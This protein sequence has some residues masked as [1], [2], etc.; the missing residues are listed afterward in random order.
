MFDGREAGPDHDFVPMMKLAELSRLVEV[1]SPGFDNPGPAVN[2]WRIGM[3]MRCIIAGEMD[4]ARMDSP[5][6]YVPVSSEGTSWTIVSQANLPPERHPRLDNDLRTLIVQCCSLNMLERPSLENVYERTRFL[7]DNR[8]AEYFKGTPSEKYETT[9][10]CKDLMARLL[11]EAE[12][13]RVIGQSMFDPP[14][15]HPDDETPRVVGG[16]MFGSPDRYPRFPEG[17][18]EEE[19]TRRNNPSVRNTPR[20]ARRVRFDLPDEPE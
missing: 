7:V 20:S 12:V 14:D 6:A 18:F 1:S 9:E 5:A 17:P 8:G 16:S 11:F 13:P 4:V 19:G 15:R 3:I 10:Y 2:I